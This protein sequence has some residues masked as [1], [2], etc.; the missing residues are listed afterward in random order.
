M[1]TLSSLSKIQYANIV[2]LLIF[3]LALVIEI[4][5]YGFDLMRIINIANFALAWYMFINIRKVQSSTRKVASVMA[6]A[7]EGIL[8]RRLDDYREGGELEDLRNNFNN[9]LDQLGLFV[10]KV[11]DSI[12]QASAKSSYPQI[13]TGAFSGQF[14]ESVET[15]NEAIAHMRDDTTA[16]A[17][18]DV[19]SEISR[20]GQG[21]IGELNLL[22]HD[23]THSLENIEKIVGASKS[24]E[25]SAVASTRAVDDISSDLHRLIEGVTHASENITALN[26]KATEI[27]SVVDLIKDI[28]DQTNLLALN[29]AIEAARAGEHGRGFAV[30]A[31]EVRK[32]AERTQKA[33]SEIAISIQTL[34]QDASDLQEGSASMSEI[35]QHSSETIENFAGQIQQFRVDAKTSSNYAHSIENMVFVILAK[36]DHTIYKSNAYS[37]VF[38]RY[39]RDEFPDS[40]NCRLGQWYQGAA[41]EKFG[42]CKS[43]QAM[44]EPHRHIH[45]LVDANIAFIEPTDCVVEHKDEIIANFNEM[46]QHSMKMYELMEAMLEQAEKRMQDASQEC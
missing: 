20:I 43:Y 9:F 4:Y 10:S 37:S 16:I 33:T 29:A 6:D 3:S 31:D 5:H 44:D 23:L 34:Q 22:Q 38:R 15:T 8:D 2:S 7:K 18:S 19:N 45:R 40:N 28:A 1:S 17:S 36:I 39:K 27:T 26:E 35:A 25:A 14:K 30:V 13:Q 41:K 11:S 32:L 21:V 42:D 12:Q 24:T 46:E